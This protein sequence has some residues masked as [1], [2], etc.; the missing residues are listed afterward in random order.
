MVVTISGHT[1]EL[2]TII[3]IYKYLNIHFHPLNLYMYVYM[4]IINEIKIFL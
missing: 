2:D 4:L 3:N 1:R